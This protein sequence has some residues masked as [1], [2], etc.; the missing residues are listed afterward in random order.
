MI[1][2]LDGRYFF[3]GTEG[4]ER[5]PKPHQVPHSFILYDILD[6]KT[7]IYAKGRLGRAVEPHDHKVFGPGFLVYSVRYDHETS[8]WQWGPK[9]P[10]K[11]R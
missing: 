7:E 5:G 11:R 10:R 8:N 6:D 9:K 2:L 4:L 1:Q 3:Q